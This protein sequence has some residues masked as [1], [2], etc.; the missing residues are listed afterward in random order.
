MNVTINLPNSQFADIKSEATPD[1]T[2][3][4]VTLVQEYTNWTSMVITITREEWEK[5]NDLATPRT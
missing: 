5:A 2:L 1:M 3:R 4:L